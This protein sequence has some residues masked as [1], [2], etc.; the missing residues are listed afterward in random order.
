MIGF[1]DI[2]YTVLGTTGDTVL[3]LIYKILQFTFTDTLGFS[4]LTCRIQA[5]DLSQSPCNFKSSKKSS[6]HRLIPFLSLFC[7]RQFRR[8]D[9]TTVL[10][11]LVVSQ[12]ESQLL[13]DGR[14]TANQLVLETSPLRL[15][16]CN[17]IFQLNT[18]GY[19][20][21]VTSPLTRGWVSRLQLLL[22]LA[23]AIILKSESRGAHDHILLSRIRDSPNL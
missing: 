5:T 20:P 15:K 7:N 17:S 8:L 1:T 19:S 11:S 4:A 22:V 18:C 16:T 2:L 23:S 9:S 14:F 10:Y 3:T 6:W 21:Y 12:S 13:Y